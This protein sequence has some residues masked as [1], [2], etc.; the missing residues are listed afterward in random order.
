M[1][2]I[3]AAGLVTALLSQASQPRSGSDQ[4]IPVS[5]GARLAVNLFAGEVVIRSWDRDA[6]RVQGDHSS[7]ER[8]EIR[9]SESVVTI[10]TVSSIGVPRS[11]D[12]QISVPSW[13]RIDVSG[14]YADVTIDGPQADISVETV[15]GDVSVKGG[16]GFISLQSVEG[17]VSLE[18]ANGRV[19]IR[20]VNEGVSALN[21]SGDLV[22][23]TVNGDMTLSRI[24]SGNVDV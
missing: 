4:T 2:H 3:I 7:K 11:V 21:V 9:P 18:N 8:I 13:M 15:R 5:R 20:S 12:M 10:K 16:V 24:Q 1:F 19:N 17:L 23:E 14:T 6:I 22:A